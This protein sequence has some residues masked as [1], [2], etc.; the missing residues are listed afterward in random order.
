VVSLA[1]L[2]ADD[3]DGREVLADLADRYF[4]GDRTALLV[5]YLDLLLDW[6]V[7]LLLRYGMALE[8][9]QQNIALVLDRVGTDT[10]LRLLFK[11]ND[12]PRIRLDRLTSAFDGALPA[13]AHPELLDDR[14]ILVDT[15]KPLV[16]V[17]TTITLHLCAGAVLFGV[18]SA[19]GPRTLRDLLA[20]A[21]DR[22][23]GSPDAALLRAATL[24][25]DRL[26][27]KAMVTAGTLLS[28]Q[29][30]GAADVNKYYRLSGPNYLAAQ[31]LPDAR[32]HRAP[33]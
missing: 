9:H 20:A 18:D 26:P 32:H 25:A 13:E 7:T 22:H 15:T 31:A 19:D 16:D 1:A 17:F 23:T 3:T 30:S 11:D 24:D 2:L 12:G 6:Q 33:A 27:V 14:R 10:R 8:S 4:G 21:I 28:K 5:D 29:R